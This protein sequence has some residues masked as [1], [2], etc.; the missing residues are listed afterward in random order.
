M[1]KLEGAERRRIPTD[2]DFTTVRGM[3]KEAAESAIKEGIVWL[4]LE[5]LAIAASIVFSKSFAQSL[6]P[7]QFMSE[8]SYE[9]LKPPTKKITISIHWR[10]LNGIKACY[11]A[12][13]FLPI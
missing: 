9:Q 7:L 2:L 1:S 11:I 5:V 8:T 4:S 13:R 3:R 12:K 6:A 10:L